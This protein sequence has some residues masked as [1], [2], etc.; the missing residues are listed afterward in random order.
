M[1]FYKESYL[2]YGVKGTCSLQCIN[3]NKVQGLQRTPQCQ[4]CK[5]YGKKKYQN[6]TNA[7]NVP[8]AGI[9]V[10]LQ[11]TGRV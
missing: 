3:L 5:I 4:V 10:I 2:R 7:L 8:G 9:T 1:R 11:V 6:L